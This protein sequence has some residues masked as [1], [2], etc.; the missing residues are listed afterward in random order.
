ND[1]RWASCVCTN[2]TGDLSYVGTNDFH[3]SFKITTTATVASA[4]VSQRATCDQAPMWDVRM[5]AQGQLGVETADGGA[6]YTGFYTIKTV[7]DGSP[8]LVALARTAGTLTVSIDG[9]VT[10]S[11]LSG[12]GFGVLPQLATGVDACDG[13]DGTSALVGTVTDLCVTPR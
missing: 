8:H 3:I 12:A 11:S 2:C 4:V 9:V 6:H 7:N 5:T 13:Q 10:G 1:P